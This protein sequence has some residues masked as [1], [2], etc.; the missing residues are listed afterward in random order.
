MI[1]SDVCYFLVLPKTCVWWA[2][3]PSSS[4]SCSLFFSFNHF[5]SF[6]WS[7]CHSPH[8]F[9]HL[10]RPSQE[11]LLV[12]V[13]NHGLKVKT[14]KKVLTNFIC[15]STVHWEP[16]TCNAFMQSGEQWSLGGTYVLIVSPSWVTPAISFPTPTTELRGSLGKYPGL[17]LCTEVFRL[18]RADPVS[19]PW[20]FSFFLVGFC[21]PQE[22]ISAQVIPIA[23]HCV[24]GLSIELELQRKQ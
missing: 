21:L 6:S 15:P 3:S 17:L 19:P 7:P 9:V 20:T 13:Y 24:H 18:A 4:P 16:T 1:E 10:I 23:N 8:P 22:Q 5:L 11:T 14:V 2:P 12:S